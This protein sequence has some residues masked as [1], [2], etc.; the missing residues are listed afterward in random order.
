MGY[1]VVR[2]GILE[3]FYH[4]FLA[5]DFREGFRSVFSIQYKISHMN[6]ENIDRT[7]GVGRIEYPPVV[8]KQ[9]T[10]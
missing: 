9:R 4:V 7:G 6:V 8:E 1:H 5:R 2:D 3:G 10:Q